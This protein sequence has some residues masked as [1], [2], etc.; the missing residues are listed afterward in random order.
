VQL[1]KVS[2]FRGLGTFSHVRGKWACSECQT[3]TQ[4]PVPA[5]II[6]KGLPTSGLLAQVLVAKY[7][8]HLPLYPQ[9]TILFTASLKDVLTRLPTQQANRIEELMPH[10]WQPQS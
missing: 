8:D 7:S 9:A 5:Q 10:R 4:A 3:L 2:E 6:D 1:Y